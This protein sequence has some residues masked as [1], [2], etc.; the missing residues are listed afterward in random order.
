MSLLQ[1]S[2]R[3]SKSALF[4]RSGPLV[5]I[6]GQTASGKSALAMQIA[7]KHDGEIV[8]A[9][10]RTVYKGMDIGTAKPPKADQKKVQHYLLDIVDPSERMSAHDFVRLSKK[11]LNS[12]WSRN[13]LPIVVG[14][15]GMY[16]DAL[17]FGYT[18]RNN[19]V[20]PLKRYEQMSLS[21]LQ[22][23]AKQRFG[24]VI[25][26]QDYKNPRRLQ[27]LLQRGFA[28][29][30]DRSALNLDCL[31]L[32][33]ELSDGVL[34]ERIRLRTKEMFTDGFTNEVK[35]LLKKYPPSAPGLQATGYR[36]V[37]DGLENGLDKDK[38][39]QAVERAT[40]QLARKQRTWFRRNKH[41]QW[42]QSSDQAIRE[43]SIYLEQSKLQ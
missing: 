35:R 41:I 16:I 17:I 9:D 23:E 26:E 31:V 2:P 27:A 43:V 10:S 42:M 21:Q 14:G 28:S 33:L 13:K 5:V 30:N 29:N 11:A 15:S 32:G 8:C 40:W 6:V 12:I 34:K 19:D 22:S 36:E 37:V 18:F 24:G 4:N 39:A 3:K 38:I 7:K 25:S 20:V 1:K